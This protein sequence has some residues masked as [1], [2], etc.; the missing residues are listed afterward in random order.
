M[1][2]NTISTICS[3]V[4]WVL[5]MLL[6]GVFGTLAFSI[7]VIALKVIGSIL[8]LA[9]LIRLPIVLMDRDEQ[10][11]F[12]AMRMGLDESAK[13]S[14]SQIEKDVKKMS[15][16]MVGRDHPTMPPEFDE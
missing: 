12:V 10:K 5:I 8:L 7:G 15:I 3:V 11:N 14:L 1:K 13:T 9:F 6:T 2:R 16:E 4:A